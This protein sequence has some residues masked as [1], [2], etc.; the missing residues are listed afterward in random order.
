DKTNEYNEKT[1]HDH[2]DVFNQLF[3]YFYQ[4]LVANRIDVLLFSRFPHLGADFLLHAIARNLGMDVVVC[5]QSLFPEKFFFVYHWEDFGNFRELAPLT[6]PTAYTM[7]RKHEAEWLSFYKPREKTN[8][9]VD[10]VRRTTKRLV[11]PSTRGE[12]IAHLLDPRHF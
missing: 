4:L 11:D 8:V 7:E 2:L 5:W 10:Q 12:T 1:F 6:T 9:L 3:D